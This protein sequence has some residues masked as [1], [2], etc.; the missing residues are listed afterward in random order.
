MSR[1]VVVCFGELL[2]RLGPPDRELLLQS[3]RLQVAYGGAEANVAVGLA[4]LGHD[5]RMVSVAADNTLGRSA[6]AELRRWGVDVGAVRPGAGRMGLYFVSPGATLR[7][8]EVLYDRAGSAFSQADPAGYDWQGD[9]QGAAWLHLSGV[10]P[11]IGPAAAAAALDAARA[12]NQAGVKVS[13]DG[14]YRARLWANRADEAPALLRGLISCAD[15]AFITD[16][17]LALVLGRD[18]EGDDVVTRRLAA[19]QAAFAAFPRLARIASVLRTAH[20][21]DRHDLSALMITRRGAVT[22]ERLRLTDVVD[23]IGAG[24]AFAAGVLHG[25]LDSLG[26]EAS[27]ACGLRCAAH[28]HGV[29]GDFGLATVEDLAAF[30]EPWVDVRR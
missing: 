29:P 30:D 13:F 22:S 6:C 11:A 16:R 17:D 3:P 4:R 1:G 15:L 23:R 28:K 7:S 27:L 12:A 26:D 8:A 19:A 9:L 5:A 25:L 2:I 21:P 10:T 24:D 14:N 18:F 20:S